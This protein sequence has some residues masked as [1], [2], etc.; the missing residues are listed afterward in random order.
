MPMPV[1]RDG[2]GWIPNTAQ[3]EVNA[4]NVASEAGNLL[5]DLD[6]ETT[7]VFYFWVLTVRPTLEDASRT[8]EVLQNG[9]RAIQL[10]P[11]DPNVWQ[12]RITQYFQEN[13]GELLDQAFDAADRP[14]GLASE[15]RVQ[16]AI[17]ER[18]S[19][20]QAEIDLLRAD[21]DRL[22]ATVETPDTGLE[23]RLRALEGRLDDLEDRIENAGLTG[24][25]RAAL[26]DLTRE[27]ATPGSLRAWWEA[28][29]SQ[30]QGQP[31]VTWIERL[32]AR[33]TG[34]GPPSGFSV[35]ELEAAIADAGLRPDEFV[36]QALLTA[37]PNYTFFA[38][39]VR[40]SW[41]PVE[42]LLTQGFP[43]NDFTAFRELARVL[44]LWRSPGYEPPT[45]PTIDW[46]SRVEG[47]G[48]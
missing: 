27:R 47:G 35:R 5:T 9:I 37:N 32:G 36:T 30:Y 7:S 22:A 3:L 1:W 41:R 26:E 44:S 42:A 4:R 2:V 16:D 39:L 8:W 13:I 15:Q 40:N 12:S 43:L 14:Q 23:D 10:D 20:R 19:E 11:Q 6:R 21:V 17:T 33:L 25:E 46:R 48:I 29:L 38:S 31:G 34:D 45:D 28:L 24:A 18:A